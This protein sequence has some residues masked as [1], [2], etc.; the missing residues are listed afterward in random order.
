MVLGSHTKPTLSKGP[1]AGGIGRLV[2]GEDWAVGRMQADGHSAVEILVLKAVL[3][4]SNA[5]VSQ[6]GREEHGS[7]MQFPWL[8]L[9]SNDLSR[10]CWARQRGVAQRRN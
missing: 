4:G 7:A 5:P 1:L 10:L 6:V 2:D 9:I 3:K 8:V